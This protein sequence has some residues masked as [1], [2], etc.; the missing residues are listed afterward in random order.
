MAA[1]TT[2]GI[3]QKNDKEV[4][5]LFDKILEQRVSNGDLTVIDATNLSEQTLAKYKKLCNEYRYR[6][7]IVDFTKVPFDQLMKQDKERGYKKVGEQVLRKFYDRIPYFKFPTWAKVISLNENIRDVIGYKKPDYSHY[8]KIVHVGDLQG[9]YTV[10]KNALGELNPNWLYIFVGDY[11]DRG[12]ENDKVLEYLFTIMELPNVILLEGNH[13]RHFSNWANNSED[14]A[15]EFKHKTLPQIEHIDKGKIRELARRLHQGL[16]YT[17]F[18]KEVLVTHCGLD[19]M[20]SDLSF[21]STREMVRAYTSYGH[22]VDTIFNSNTAENQYQVHGHRNK[23]SLPI[24]NDRSFNLEG[25]VEFGGHLR[26]ATL[27]KEGWA[28]QEFKNE[29]YFKAPKVSEIEALR[30]SPLVKERILA[31]GISSFNFTK[32]AFFDRNWTDVAIKARGLFVNTVTGKIAARSFDKF[33]YIGEF[34]HLELENIKDKLAFPIR[35]FYKENG[36]L[37]IAGY[38]SNNDSLL[39]CSKSMDDGE[40]AKYFQDIFYSKVNNPEMFKNFLKINNV[41][42]AF[43]VIDPVNDPHIIEYKEKTLVILGVIRNTWEFELLDI[44]ITPYFT[45]VE[46]AYECKACELKDIKQLENL[47]INSQRTDLVKLEGFVLRDQNNWM[48]KVKLPYYNFW[49]YVRG[50]KDKLCNPKTNR[51]DLRAKL[52]QEYWA[53]YEFML[54]IPVEE[55]EKMS[56]IELRRLYENKQKQE[57]G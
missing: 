22:H 17:Y 50:L 9:C 29:V 48:F 56:V 5:E 45:G 14:Y 19:R 8:E 35:E 23:G 33:F 7:F 27:S 41:S 25:E 32:E 52:A 34:R 20:P 39:L 4:F 40:F 6:A 31:N 43:E 28:T 10:T 13:E 49:K 12:I 57:K 30:Q 24:Q 18:E 55:L 51:V 37:G 54:T 15:A 53:V 11:L 21:I 26:I 36:F 2:S 38:N 44:D 16:H 46:N 47:L 1:P 3:V 42:V